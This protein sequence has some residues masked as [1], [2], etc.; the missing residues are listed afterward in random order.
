MNNEQSAQ[1]TVVNTA[2]K[3]SYKE[4][5]ELYVKCQKDL[6]DSILRERVLESAAPSQVSAD[7]DADCKNF[8]V[9]W[10]GY[11]SLIDQVE[12]EVKEL[13]LK[14]HTPKEEKEEWISVEDRLPEIGQK[15]VLSRD[16]IE[17]TQEYVTTFNQEDLNWLKMNDVTHW[18]P[19]PAPPKEAEQNDKA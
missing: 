5:W 12:G 7:L 6:H 4:L 8:A 17:R 13:V 15:V 18:M 2:R 11:Y 14:Y 9:R 16:L 1:H 3:L 10:A 19:L